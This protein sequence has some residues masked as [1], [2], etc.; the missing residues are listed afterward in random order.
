MDVGP[1]ERYLTDSPTHTRC[2][3]PSGGHR[4]QDNQRPH[5]L[6]THPAILNK[7]IHI[8]G[9]L[10]VDLFASRLIYTNCLATS[11]GDRPQWRNQ[12]NFDARA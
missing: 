11:V 4:V 12:T 7:I 10:E 3:Q 2:N 8:F 6:E 5:R 1:S 9:T